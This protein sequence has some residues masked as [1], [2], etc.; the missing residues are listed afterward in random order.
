MIPNVSVLI[1][2]YI[3]LTSHQDACQ[4]L[5]KRLQPII[6]Q[7]PEGTWNDWVRHMN[8]TKCGF[9]PCGNCEIHIYKYSSL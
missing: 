9:Y 8:P 3:L 4:T 5:L 1:L 2:C 7:N 6:N